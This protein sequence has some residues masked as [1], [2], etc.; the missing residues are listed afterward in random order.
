MLT[1]HLGGIDWEHVYENWSEE[2]KD[3]QYYW[4]DLPIY[5]QPTITKWG[6]RGFEEALELAAEG[7][8]QAAYRLS[9]AVRTAPDDPQSIRA[10]EVL[11]A[12][13]EQQ[14][15]QQGAKL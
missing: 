2:S 12:M 6:E 10:M 11:T 14:Q 8:A 7:N 13:Q 3:L 5:T 4:D 9:R 1:P 15:Q